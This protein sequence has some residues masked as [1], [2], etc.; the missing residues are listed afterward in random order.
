MPGYLS[1]AMLADDDL[2][3]VEAA[4]LG[5][6]QH[7]LARIRQGFTRMLQTGGTHR[8][9]AQAELLNHMA[10]VL[11]KT[12]AVAH[13][14]GER[15]SILMAGQQR[16]LSFDRFSEVMWQVRSAGLG[17]NL[18][19][20]Q[21]GYAHRT[22]DAL[23]QMG[24]NLDATTQATIASLIAQKEP[25]GRAIKVLMATLDKLGV[26]EIGQS[27]LE[28]VYRTASAAAFNS[29]RWSRDQSLDEIWGYVL[30][31]Q[32]DSKVRP[33]H[34]ALDG[35]TLPKNDRFWRTHWVPLGWNCRCII[36]TL[37]KRRK[38]V[39]PG[40]IEGKVPMADEGFRRNWGKSW[41]DIS[42]EN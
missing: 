28:T 16:A 33:T 21:R 3:R 42:L 10:P 11:A 13:L 30:V 34:A 19:R 26:G 36:A 35:T 25:P 6:S 37:M 32:R 1:Q 38:I 20:L 39:Q 14:M 2:D 4:G 31:S 29:G 40:R 5:A 41:G 15:R 17:D 24:A 12:M 27:R 23:R 22:Y 9:S 8:F 18:S 7:T